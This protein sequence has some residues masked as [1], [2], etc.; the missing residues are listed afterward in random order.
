MANKNDII[1]PTCVQISRSC[2]KDEK[3]IPFSAE[4]LVIA[5]KAA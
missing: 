4:K 3:V 1:A 2:A 5:T